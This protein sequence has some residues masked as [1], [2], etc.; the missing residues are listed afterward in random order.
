MGRVGRLARL[1]ANAIDDPQ[2]FRDRWPAAPEQ[3]DRR[4]PVP[5]DVRAACV[6]HRLH[7]DRRQELLD[8][9][10][11]E[12]ALHEVVA[13]DFPDE[14]G[15]ATTVRTLDLC[16]FEE[17]FHEWDNQREESSTAVISVSVRVTG[18]RIVSGDVRRVADDGVVPAAENL[19][20]LGSVLALVHVGNVPVKAASV[21]EHRR[22]VCRQGSVEEAV[23]GGEVQPEG[24][25]LGETT[26][27]AA[28]QREDRQPEAGD[29]CR[30]WVEVDARNL[31]E[32]ALGED[33]RCRSRLALL[34]QREE[35]LERADQEVT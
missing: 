9:R 13:G 18:C 22:A 26:D 15:A 32:T 23:A 35:P 28:S 5:G 34:P 29:R 6:N 10:R 21:E 12:L 7:V 17:P 25:G 11:A 20:Q 24:R 19:L 3:E 4:D 27:L 31:V 8:E 30:E 1:A 2:R 16:E 14:P 33:G